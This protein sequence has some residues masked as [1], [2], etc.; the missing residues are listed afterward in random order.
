MT[1]FKLADIRC[2][3]LRWGLIML[4][5]RCCGFIMLDVCLGV[6]MLDVPRGVS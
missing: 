4:D 6:T 5:V 2:E 1:G 3:E